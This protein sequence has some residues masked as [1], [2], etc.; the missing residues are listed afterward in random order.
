MENIGVKNFQKWDMIWEHLLAKLS[1]KVNYLLEDKIR[2]KAFFNILAQTENQVYFQ[3]LNNLKKH[4]Y[5]EHF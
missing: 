2:D 4:N 3:T 5:G 1:K